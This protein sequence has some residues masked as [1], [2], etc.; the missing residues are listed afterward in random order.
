MRPSTRLGS[1]E[2]M[3]YAIVLKNDSNPVAVPFLDKG[4]DTPSGKIITSLFILSGELDSAHGSN[5]TR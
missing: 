4:Q 1:F 5:S 3:G 2:D